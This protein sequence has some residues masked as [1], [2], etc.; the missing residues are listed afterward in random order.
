MRP[1]SARHAARSAAL[2]TAI[3]LSLPASAAASTITVSTTEDQLNADP[4]ACSLREAI[5]AANH[6]SVAQ[7]PGCGAGGSVDA[8]AVPAG[9]YGLTRQGDGENADLTGDL[10]VTAPA[11]IEHFGPGSTVVDANGIDRAFETSAAGGV[12]L[13]GL[14]IEGGHAAGLGTDDEARSGG[15]IRNSGGLLIVVGSTLTGNFADAFGGGVE[16]V[17]GSTTQLLD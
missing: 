9:T 14:T 3:A 15:G 7:A 2:A 10:D 6:D 4:A 5:W 13:S 16:S 12:T 17:A 1:L 8:G 11:T